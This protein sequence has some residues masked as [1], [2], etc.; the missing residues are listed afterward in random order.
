L[1]PAKAGEW[2]EVGGEAPFS[3]YFSAETAH[4]TVSGRVLG[5]NFPTIS[6]LHREDGQSVGPARRW[7]ELGAAAL[8]APV[9][10]LV[11]PVLAQAAPAARPTR[12]SQ[13]AYAGSR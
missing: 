12:A 9:D 6:L 10:D 3:D 1:R 11:Q 5:H 13:G 8:L 2:A 7:L 4:R